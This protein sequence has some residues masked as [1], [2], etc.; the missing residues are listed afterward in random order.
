MAYYAS[1]LQSLT[2]LF[3]SVG[4]VRKVA[5]IKDKEGQ[6]K[7]F[8]FVNYALEQDADDAVAR[9]DGHEHNGRRLR[10]EKA[11]QK[12]TKPET[13]AASREA[14]AGHGAQQARPGD[15]AA[16]AGDPRNTVLILGLSESIT[17]KQLQQRVS[18]LGATTAVKLKGSASTILPTAT[19]QAA[20]ITYNLASD[21]KK[22]EK[23]LHNQ[24]FKGSTMLSRRLCGITFD[25]QLMQKFRLIVRN[26]NFEVRPFVATQILNLTNTN[27]AGHRSRFAGIVLS[28]CTCAQY[29][30]TP[31][32]N[33]APW[34]WFRASVVS[35]RCPESNRG[36]ER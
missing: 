3:A 13:T 9:F 30:F 21:A 8:G 15:A 29:T 11:V 25:K 1:L 36:C 23:K 22:A 10:V 18:K 6:P 2:E 19:G 31:E 28:F 24:L 20:Y 33:I 35:K 26:L 14:P 7:G 27:L 4:P 12:G 17:E 34:F 32:G 5:V 16:S